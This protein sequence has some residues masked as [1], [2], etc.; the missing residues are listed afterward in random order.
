MKKTK[1]GKKIF[2]ELKDKETH[3]LEEA[4]DISKKVTASKNLMSLLIFL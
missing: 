1:K 4:I 2:E 3:K